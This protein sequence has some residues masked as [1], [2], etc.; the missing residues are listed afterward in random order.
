MK[1]YRIVKI[2][3]SIPFYHKNIPLIIEKKKELFCKTFRIIR[4]DSESKQ[5]VK[6][7]LSSTNNHSLT[8]LNNIIESE[9]AH[10]S[11]NTY[12][13]ELKPMY[14]KISTSSSIIKNKDSIINDYELTC[15]LIEINMPIVPPLKMK[16]TSQYPN[17]PPEI[18]SLIST[19]MNVTP[20]K[21]ENSGTKKKIK[22]KK[23]FFLY[24]IDGNTFFESISRNFVCFLF[25]LPTQHTVTDILDIWVMFFIIFFFN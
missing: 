9:F 2:L 12:S 17:E 7:N 24:I 16:L 10:L 11:M 25:K 8:L 15:R 4:L 23:S 13:Y 18:L 20:T 6:P 21:L 1:I 14:D 3:I 19:A 22:I 5:I